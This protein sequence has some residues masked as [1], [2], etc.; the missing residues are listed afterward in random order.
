MDELEKDKL[1]ESLKDLLFCPSEEGTAARAERLEMPHM[2][3]EQLAT[4]ARTIENEIIPRLMLSYQRDIEVYPVPENAEAIPEEFAI[5]DF[6][7]QLLSPDG[8]EARR[9]VDS[10]RARGTALEHIYLKL[11]A[12]AARHMGWMWEEDLCNFGEVTVG[13]ARLQSMLLEFGA[14]FHASSAPDRTGR[15]ALLVSAPGEQHTFGLFMLTEFFRRDGWEVW[16]DPVAS[17]EALSSMV[18]DVWFDVVGISA[19]ST[20]QLDDLREA[21]MTVRSRSRNRAVIVLVG[22][23]LLLAHPE[24]LEITGADGTGRDGG[25]ALAVANRLVRTSV[26][27]NS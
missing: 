23:P 26:Q 13:L 10:A 16:G 3:S 8:R 7:G 2:P 1:G 22:G 4:L 15:R 19:G 14:A 17:I 5:E 12:P 9:Y 20:R 21:V 24:Y 6:V 25:E 18:Q 11:M 27:R